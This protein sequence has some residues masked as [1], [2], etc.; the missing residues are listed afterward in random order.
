MSKEEKRFAWAIP[1]CF[2]ILY[3]LPLGV[4]PLWIPDEVRYAEIPREMLASGNWIVPHLDGLRYFEKP[5]FGYWLNALSLWTFGEN[6]FASRLPSAL[7]AGLTALLLFLLTLRFTKRLLAA[8]FCAALFLTSFEVFVIGVFNVLDSLFALSITA[9]LVAFFFGIQS[10]GKSQRYYLALFGFACGMGFLIKGFLAF[11][12]PVL[13][14]VPFM[15]WEN[16]W[17]ELFSCCWLPLGTALLTVLPWSLAVYLQA[18]DYWH[19]FFWVEHIKRFSAE[20]AP[21]LKPFWF[22]IPMLM[23]GAFPW[24]VF[25]P[26]AIL[27]L[28]RSRINT[29]LMRFALCWLLFPFLFL[30]FSKGKL[31]T[32]ILPCF[33]PL[34]ILISLGLWQQ[35]NQPVG[36]C[37]KWGERVIITLLAL[38]AT[39]LLCIQLFDFGVKVY[40]DPGESWKYLVVALSVG[41]WIGLTRSAM[42]CA[43]PL[44]RVVRYSA[45]PLAFM[46]SMHFTLPKQV[47]DNKAPASFLQSVATMISPQTLIVSDSNMSHAVAWQYKRNDVFLISS[48]ELE[49]GLTYPDAQ[50]RFLDKE[51][52]KQFLA[53]YQWKRPIAIFYRD[54]EFSYNALLPANVQSFRYG[55]CGM[56]FLK[57]PQ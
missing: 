34:A 39:A 33:A 2:I 1:V 3:I 6:A 36:K 21:H 27:S 18:P 10:N 26:Q 45:A 22:Y 52:F 49:Y 41:V 16:R 23:I 37:A 42:S 12:L 47:E 7:A 44:Q 11:A 24:S 20:N 8:A 40:A 38:F 17:K 50:Q 51:K 32:Y 31:G 43:A 14:I 57:G 15:I 46:L 55:K 5:V 56:L 9:S 4:R 13:V 35:F 48:G 19:Y 29:P 53:Q 54:R 25:A 28:W 30:S